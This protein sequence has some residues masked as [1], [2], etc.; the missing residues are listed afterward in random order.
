[1][2]R[3]LIE[4]DEGEG[5]RRLIAP[6]SYLD[7]DEGRAFCATLIAEE[8]SPEFERF[9]Q[10]QS[11]A[12][13][14]ADRRRARMTA[15]E[16]DALD[17]RPPALADQLRAA[18]RLCAALDALMT[19]NGARPDALSWGR[20]HTPGDWVAARL[21]RPYAELCAALGRTPTPW[22]HKRIPDA[23]RRAAFEPA[24]AVF[25][26]HLA[27]LLTPAS[28]FH[29]QRRTLQHGDRLT[30]EV[31][32]HADGYRL[33]LRRHE[34]DGW[35][36]EPTPARITSEDYSTDAA[37]YGACCA[38]GLV[39]AWGYVLE[40]GAEVWGYL[41]EHDARHRARV[42]WDGLRH[43]DASPDYLSTLGDEL[44]R[45]GM[46]CRRRAGLCNAEGGAL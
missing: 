18:T 34:G 7:S 32:K 12:A 29:L 30:F 37:L 26:A 13:P 10:A 14:V 46:E 28:G 16:V 1:M 24:F 40:D 11:A 38:L 31:A 21:A 27:E 36:T 33:E 39:D 44:H 19:S 23:D 35:A 20:D 45:L 8:G 3:V 2:T 25:K 4:I 43:A 9:R 5:R 42:A 41:T 15:E 22:G 6:A 17:A